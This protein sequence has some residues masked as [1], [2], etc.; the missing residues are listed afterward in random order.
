MGIFRGMGDKDHTETSTHSG[1]EQIN[2]NSLDNV[3]ATDANVQNTSEITVD[4]TG[5]E[6]GGENT[7]EV[8]TVSASDRPRR[9]TKPSGKSIESTTQIELNKLDKAWTK[10]K[11]AVTTLQ[12]APSS[13]DEIVK[14]IAQVRAE[15][16]VYDSLCNSFANFLTHAGTRECLEER[17]KLDTLANNNKQFVSENIEQGNQRKQEIMC[18]IKSMRSGSMSR[19]SSMSSTALRAKA[20][21][22]AAAAIK[23]V[24]MRKKHSLAESQSALNIQREELALAKRKLEEQA[25]LETLRLEEDAAVAVARAQAID[26]ELGFDIG[27][28][29]NPI[30]LPV[31]SPQTRV[32]LF[33]EEQCLQ[34]QTDDPEP[35][36][37]DAK[38]TQTPS[39]HLSPTVPSFTPNNALTATNSDPSVMRSCLEFMAHREVI[40]K[41]VD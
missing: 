14:A 34:P 30:D 41:K 25:R 4:E 21:A 13:I 28:E 36:R 10:V 27:N 16:N 29:Q 9:N 31:E 17:Y 38:N 26:D 18:E 39:H 33:I 24:E 15:H 2:K 35:T 6:A 5:V 8:E 19:A 32:Q 40:T 20:R 7:N 37:H 3:L 23:K 1:E 11:R 22:E 12:N